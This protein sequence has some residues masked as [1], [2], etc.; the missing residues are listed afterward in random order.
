VKSDRSV[1][2]IATA[3]MHPVVSPAGVEAPGFR[4]DPAD[5]RGPYSPDARWIWTDN[6]EAVGARFRTEF[7]LAEKPATA[8]VRITADRKYRLWVNG[9]LASRGP[10]DHGRDY[11]K[12]STGWWFYDVRDLAGFFTAGVNVIAVEVFHRWPVEFVVTSGRGGFWLDGESVGVRSDATWRASA[13]GGYEIADDK[14]V[15]DAAAEP[16]RW[17]DHGFDDP[18]WPGATVVEHGHWRALV[19]SEI[20]PLMEVRYPPVRVEKLDEHGSVRLVFDRVLSGYAVLQTRGGNGA[21][22]EITGFRKTTVR[23]GTLG[24]KEE[25]DLAVASATPPASSRLRRADREDASGVEDDS[26]S[27]TGSNVH[28]QGAIFDFETFYMDEIPGLLDV[29]VT[30]GDAPIEILDIG[31][32]FTSQ[33]VEYLGSF[34]CGDEFLNKLWDVGRWAVRINLQTHHLDSPNHQEPIACP[35]DYVIESAVNFYCFGSPWLARQDLRKFA[36]VLVDLDYQNFHTS[37]A[38]CWLQWLRDYVMFTGDSG[39]AKELSPVVF[40][41]LEKWKTYIGDNGILSRAPNFMFM[42]WVTIA[43]FNCHHPPAVV[44]QGYLTAFFC[45]GLSIGGWIAGMADDPKMAEEFAETRRQVVRSFQRELW[46]PERGLFRDGRPFVSTAEP[47]KWLPADVDAETF[48]P[49]VNL[50]AVLY[51]IAPK[52]SHASIVEAVLAE[53]PLNVQPWFMHWVFDAID[54]AGL[55]EKRAVA[56]LRRWEVVESSRSFRE[57]WETGDLSHGWCSTPTVQLSSRVL[58]VV[59]TSPGYATFDVRPRP[60]G[61]TF[62]RG[63]V[64]T[65]RGLI[66]VDWTEKDGRIDLNLKVPPGS[67]GRVIIDG[68]PLGLF[69]PGPYAFMGW[70]L[71]QGRPLRTRNIDS[72][73]PRS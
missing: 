66:E 44:G 70:C 2:P 73:R 51:D 4:F 26:A 63:T 15:I 7:N 71:L 10:A 14:V 25:P 56:L 11:F 42:D 29:V 20:P 53:H 30:P 41:L 8:L 13:V 72:D 48:S 40:R 58:G 68:R 17:R 55:F 19:P 9:T 54:H 23:V 46:N 49:H 16:P 60:C 45:D 33:P 5:V 36:R 31:V 35:G 67:V 6:P 28:D 52:E 27:R 69:G 1:G 12:G 50:L 64:P 38:I 32:V 43:G 37:Y 62:A 59:P 57:M 65:P 22:V 39:L 24:T 3:G 34:R 61:L 47:G 18:A 21:S